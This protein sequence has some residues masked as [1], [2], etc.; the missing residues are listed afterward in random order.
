MS[1][2][3]AKLKRVLVLFETNFQNTAFSA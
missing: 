1:L 2:E 3:S